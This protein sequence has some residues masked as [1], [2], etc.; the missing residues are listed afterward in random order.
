MP[1]THNE[2]T[3]SSLDK[4][5][6]NVSKPGESVLREA[7]EGRSGLVSRQAK[8]TERLKA[9]GSSGVSQEFGKIEFYE[10]GQHIPEQLRPQVQPEPDTNVMRP[11]PPP[12]APVYQVLIPPEQR[13]HEKEQASIEKE[14]YVKE[15]AE[16]KDEP[17][18]MT[19]IGD[20]RQMSEQDIAA[21]DKAKKE[22]KPKVENHN[23]LSKSA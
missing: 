13:Q 6:E 17:N 2:R 7:D 23:A 3:E 19:R 12:E 4:A 8:E 18:M 1:N 20:A 21:L 11:I 9:G 10:G 16:P 22:S 15:H 5:Q 14:K